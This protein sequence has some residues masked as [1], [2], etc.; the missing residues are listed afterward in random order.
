MPS[1]LVVASLQVLPI[2]RLILIAIRVVHVDNFFRL[3]IA[4][5]HASVR[6]WCN[7]YFARIGI[8]RL[9]IVNLV[10]SGRGDDHDRVTG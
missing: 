10:K 4:G 2:N 7:V 9:H 6:R 5:N 1:L 3:T 8:P